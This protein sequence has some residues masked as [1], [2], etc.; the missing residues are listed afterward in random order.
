MY[1]QK[2]TEVSEEKITSLYINSQVNT[3]GE[4]LSFT[5]WG[6]NTFLKQEL[7]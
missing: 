3:T 6:K 4:L 5:P 1:T 2:K 7:S